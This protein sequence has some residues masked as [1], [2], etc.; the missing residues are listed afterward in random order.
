ME[1]IIM[2]VDAALTALYI[3][4]SSDMPKE[5]YI[6]DIIEK[7]VTIVH[8]QMHK[9]IFPSFDPVYKAD[10]KSKGLFILASHLYG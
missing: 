3:M 10:P 2:A 5:V 8:N 9:A 7:I 1:R 6:E 4:T